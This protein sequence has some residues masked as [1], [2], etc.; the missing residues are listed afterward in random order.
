MTEQ[1]EESGKPANVVEKMVEG[2][3]RKFYQEF[4]LV[5]QAFVMDPDVTVGKFIETHAKELGATMNLKGFANLK[6]ARESRRRRPISPLKSPMS[7]N[8]EFCLCGTRGFADR[9]GGPAKPMRRAARSLVA[10]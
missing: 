10:I 3:L 5:E 6:S 1:A 8:P 4:V 9:V 2:R 7:A